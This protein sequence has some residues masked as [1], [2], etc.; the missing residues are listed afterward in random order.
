MTRGEKGERREE[1][2]GQGETR[3]EKKGR[4]RVASREEERKSGGEEK[5]AWQSAKH[6]SKTQKRGSRA[7]TRPRTRVD[8]KLSHKLYELQFVSKRVRAFPNKVV[9]R[10]GCNFSHVACWRKCLVVRI[11][12]VDEN[13]SYNQV[14]LD[15]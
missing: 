9:T 14:D 5:I 13:N 8:V 4:K 2:R 10:F 7:H 15:S 6:Q 12:E 1:K 11:L 3:K